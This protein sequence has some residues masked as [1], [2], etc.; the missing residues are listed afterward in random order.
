MNVVYEN[1][2]FF[3]FSDGSYVYRGEDIVSYC[4]LYHIEDCERIQEN[5]I[6][7]KKENQ[8]YFRQEI[9]CMEDK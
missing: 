6:K 4:G 1:E 9:L 8:N 3:L 5:F 7:M 2:D